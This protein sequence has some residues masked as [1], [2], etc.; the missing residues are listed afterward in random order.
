MDIDSSFVYIKTN[1]G[2]AENAQTRFDTSYQ[3]LNRSLPKEL[4]KKVIAVTK[5]KLGGKI[6]KEY[7]AERHNVF[8]EE[9][10]RLF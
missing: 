8:T 6:M 2:I 3:V 7:E 5:D 9:L 4:N 1:G 10:I